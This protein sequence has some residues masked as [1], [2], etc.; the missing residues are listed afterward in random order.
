MVD[1]VAL[2]VVDVVV[3]V[4][5][6]LVVVDVVVAGVVDDIVVGVVDDVVVVNL[7]NV[8]IRLIGLSGSKS[9]S[10]LS[11]LSNVLIETQTPCT[12]CVSPTGHSQFLK[13]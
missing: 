6:A 8:P 1:D 3:V 4:D 5:V 12:F 11:S 2:M 10:S 13:H 9:Y 7:A